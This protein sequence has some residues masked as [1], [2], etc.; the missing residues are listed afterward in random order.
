[1]DRSG[2]WAEPESLLKTTLKDGELHLQASDQHQDN[3]LAAVRSRKDPV[4]D[5]DA[6]HV[7]SYLGLVA[8]ISA[9][10]QRKLR[11]D[12]KAENFSNHDEANKLLTRPMHNGWKV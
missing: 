4:S 11:W 5:V 6:T 8:E 7:A 2:I 1:M 12:P 10:L 3:F 9:R